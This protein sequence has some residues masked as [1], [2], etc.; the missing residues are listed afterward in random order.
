M[1]CDLARLFGELA[2]K[3]PTSGDEELQLSV[4]TLPRPPAHLTTDRI[5]I[6]KSIHNYESWGFRADGVHF[7]ADKSTYRHLGLLILAV[8]F[9]TEPGEVQVEL[10][11]RASD[12]KLLVVESPFKDPFGIV[13]GYNSR[14]FV[15]SY[16]PQ[17]TSR[18]PWVTG[19]DPTKL[20]CFYL[21]N[22]ENSVGLSEED[23][24]KRDTVRGFGSDLGSTRLAELLLNA[25]QPDNQVVEYDLE[26]DG[27]FRGVGYLSAEAKFW[28]PGSAAWDPDQWDDE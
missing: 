14:P 8:V 6:W 18:F 11:H 22:R 17:A 12:V 28:L 26:G 3:L 1:T 2:A 20:P 25:S 5:Y 21:T 19:E 24:A 27:G 13:Q 16:W 10:T 15:F 7:H 4:A 23:R 9:H